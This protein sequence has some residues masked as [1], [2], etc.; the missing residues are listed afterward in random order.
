MEYTIIVRLI[1]S[2]FLAGLVGWQRE[3]AHTP[4]GLRTHMLV[5]LGATIFTLI[6][7]ELGILVG[8]DTTR[9]TAGIVTGIGFLGA[10]TIIQYQDSIRGLSTAASIWTVAA[11]GMAVGYGMYILSIIGAVL[12]LLILLLE[13]VEKKLIK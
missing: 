9:I 12:T 4:A 13:G 7:N 1:L 3:R 10:G 2:V 5:A 8:I 11:I 6:A